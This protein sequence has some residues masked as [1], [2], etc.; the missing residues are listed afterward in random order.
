MSQ[1]LCTIG[2]Q[3]VAYGLRSLFKQCK[4]LTSAG[5]TLDGLLVSSNLW[6]DTLQTELFHQPNHTPTATHPDHN[7]YSID[8]LMLVL[9]VL[10]YSLKDKRYVKI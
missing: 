7:G 6:E 10:A 9:E 5:A 4:P 1:Y 8:N 2:Y 3:L